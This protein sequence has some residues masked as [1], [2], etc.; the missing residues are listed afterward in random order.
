M[1]YFSHW[2]SGKMRKHFSCK[3]AILRI[4]RRRAL[5]D[6]TKELVA[7]WDGERESRLSWKEV[8]LDLKRRS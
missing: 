7:V 3:H 2:H 1:L 8:L 6:G 4:A 5:P